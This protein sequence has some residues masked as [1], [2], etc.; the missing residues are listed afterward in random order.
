M[1]G[2]TGSGFRHTWEAGSGSRR[3]EAVG[4]DIATTICKQGE[5]QPGK[6]TLVWSGARRY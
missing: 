2:F 3:I 1:H 4:Y 5:P 6:T